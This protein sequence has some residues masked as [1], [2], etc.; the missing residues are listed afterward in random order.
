[1]NTG[2]KR[3]LRHTYLQ[4]C[5]RLHGH[6]LLLC[7]TLQV[8]QGGP[9]GD[10]SA[11]DLFGSLFGGMFGGGGRQQQESRRTDDLQVGYD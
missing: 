10:H 7:V 2:K 3:S 9:G 11:H 8:K 6:C 4:S 1:M 5:S